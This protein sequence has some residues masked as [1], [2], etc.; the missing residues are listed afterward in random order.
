MGGRG[1]TRPATSRGGVACGMAIRLSSRWLAAA[2]VARGSLVHG[3]PF[4]SGAQ[5]KNGSGRPRS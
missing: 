4:V 5:Y 1:V 2:E 3:D